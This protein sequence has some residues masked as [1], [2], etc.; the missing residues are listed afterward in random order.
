MYSVDVVS[1][2]TMLY[3]GKSKV[4]FTKQ[5]VQS[6]KKSNFKKAIITLA[7]GQRIDFYSN[8]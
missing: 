3:L 8:I 4:R 5:G 6:G 2:N 1:V 7:E